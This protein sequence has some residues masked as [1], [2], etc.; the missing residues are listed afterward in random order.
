MPGW[1]RANKF[2]P[3]EQME[4]HWAFTSRGQANTQE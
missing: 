4:Y 2:S 3:V 1:A